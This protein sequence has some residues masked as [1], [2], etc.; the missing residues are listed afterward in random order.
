MFNDILKPGVHYLLVKHDAWCPGVEGA[1][2]RCICNPDI[3]QV[4]EQR[5]AEAI[6]QTRNRAQRRADAK[7]RGGK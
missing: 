4:T 5:I 6:V 7:K 3:E 1:G 2:D